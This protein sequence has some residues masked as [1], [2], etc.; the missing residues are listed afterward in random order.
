MRVILTTLLISCFL[1]SA[2]PRPTC[3]QATIKGSVT[4][5]TN[6][7]HLQDANVFLS[8]TRIGT[9]TNSTGRYQLTGIPPGGYRLV[10]S[11][12]GYKKI[13]KNIIVGPGENREMTF[14]LKPVVY[15]LPEIYVGNLGKKWKKN[16]K[17][18]RNY[19]IGETKW[20]DSVKILNPEVLRFDRNWWGRFTAEAL[21]PLKIENWAL[22]YKITYY[23][24]EF[25][26][27]GSRT[28]WDG[29]PLFTEMEP[30][31]SEQAAY[32]RQNR[33]EAFYGS[34]R[35]FLLSLLQDRV[36]EEGFI[37]YN[38]RQDVYG[39]SHQNR[40]RT[41]AHQ[42]IEET[43][44]RYTYHLNFFGRL[45]I[46][47]TRDDEDYKYLHWAHALQRGPAGAQVSYLELNQHPVTV[48]A[49]GEIL[50]PYGATQFGYFSFQRLAELTPEEYRPKGYHKAA[51]IHV[52]NE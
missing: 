28:R 26:H 35:H 19:F 21:A 46:I 5:S 6:G 18:F 4:D 44:K 29:D 23:M 8:G 36:Q 27:G 37:I 32:W 25:H 39:Y 52:E 17:R 33:K 30:A 34:L 2:S 1:I 10:V 15:Q 42:L 43:E 40:S 48:N 22:G 11:V 49:N 24:R 31:D 16:L 3:A 51:N 45:E 9:A 13:V 47:Y 14:K 20:A 7:H 12:I 38:I 50:Q 41:T